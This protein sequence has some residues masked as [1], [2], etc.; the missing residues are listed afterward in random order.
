M[1]ETIDD[2]TAGDWKQTIDLSPQDKGEQILFSGERQPLTIAQLQKQSYELAKEK[3]WHDQERSPLEFYMLIVSEIAEA[4]EEARKEYSQPVW[5][6]F[7]DG[8]PEG[9]LIELADAVI[10]IADYAESRGVKLSDEWS[11]N[12]MKITGNP[13]DM[14]MV[15]VMEISD[16]AH[17]SIFENEH[18]EISKLNNTIHYIIAYCKSRGWDLEEAIRIK[19]EYN[20]TRPHRHGGKLY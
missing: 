7:P 20:K 18:A 9:E 12:E 11:G 16:G 14:H 6:N 10:R 5:R 3:G 17:Y 8:K 19:H 2:K 13:L 1:N 15:F 4:T